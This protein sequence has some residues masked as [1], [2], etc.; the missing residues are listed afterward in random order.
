MKD[1]EFDQTEL[2]K[3]QAFK[4]LYPFAI[5]CFRKQIRNCENDVEDLASDIMVD[6]LH[7]KWDTFETRTLCGLRVW[8]YRAVRFKALD[9]L[10]K[11]AAQPLVESIGYAMEN[12]PDLKY[13]SFASDATDDED[14]EKL[15]NYIR[16][17]LSPK[18]YQHFVLRLHDHSPPEIAKMMD[19]GE[20]AERTRYHRIRK[21]LQLELKKRTK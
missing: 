19:L 13:E 21:M 12:N 17:F 5:C 6:L 4:K 3:E 2:T 10:K 20:A 1:K 11:R 14:A 8:V 15:M 7:S 16:N 9:Y 18:D